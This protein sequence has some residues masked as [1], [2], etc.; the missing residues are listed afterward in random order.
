MIV[1]FVY[2]TTG[3][4]TGGE[5]VLYEL[6][7][8]LS[9][10]GCTVNFLHGPA[11]PNR[12]DSLDRLP[13]AAVGDGVRHVLFDGLD[14][15]ALPS[16]DVIFNSSAPRRLG[17]PATIIQG[18]R[19]LSEEWE[20]DAFRSPGP[21]ICVAS[22]LQ[23]VG[24]T[25]GVPRHQLLHVPPGLDHGRFR[26]SS[27]L[28]DRSIDVTVLHHPHREKDWPTAQAMLAELRVRR[29]DAR[30]V[31]FGRMLDDRIPD[32]V[33]IVDSP[34]HRRLA[35]EIY[36]D[37]RVFV[38]ASRNE[39]FGLTPVEAMACGTALVSTD[40]GGSRD[41][42]IPGVTADVVAAGDA[43]ALA[44]A[45]DRLLDD[46]ER[47][48]RYAAAGLAHALT[49]DWDRS[50]RRLSEILAAYVADPAPF[51]EPPADP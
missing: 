48:L 2:P 7:R 25:Y 45:V 35:E 20:R 14:D 6:A 32:G 49:F 50:G 9:R 47:R 40:C 46:E 23:D 21:K 41:Y 10:A 18:Y 37:T 12:I 4:V 13:S 8:A 34:D 5:T 24:E 30:L 31:T 38:Q 3:N 39:G 19:M 42:A 11:W 51:L 27:P 33:E 16:G 36:A 43:A 28:E 15:P 44:D 22:W 1:Q 29:P 17:L 26:Q